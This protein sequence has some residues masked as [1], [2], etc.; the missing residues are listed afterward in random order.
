V[1]AVLDRAQ[2]QWQSFARVY[3]VQSNGVHILHQFVQRVGATHQNPEPAV[4]DLVFFHNTYDR[5][6]DAATNDLWTHIGIV[7]G[8]DRDQTVTFHHY[9][10]GRVRKSVMNLRHP[11]QHQRNGKI[12][13][14]YLRR[15]APSASSQQPLLAALL[16]ADFGRL[17]RP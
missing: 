9:L 11:Y 3:D 2:L 4:G 8:M 16:F 10:N 12:I 13:N 15:R 17:T 14:T 1:Q 6:R 7:T 5:N